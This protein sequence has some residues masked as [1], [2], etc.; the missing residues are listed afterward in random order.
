MIMVTMNT[1]QEKR[2]QSMQNASLFLEILS[3]IG[4]ANLLFQ[5]AK[6]TA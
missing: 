5:H 1:G 6:S 2:L 3:T 4:D